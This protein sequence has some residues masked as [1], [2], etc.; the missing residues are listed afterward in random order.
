MR[1]G[2][3]AARWERFDAGS[4]LWFLRIYGV[5]LIVDVVTEMA[6]GVWDV[7][8]GRFYPWRH[9]G[10]VPLYPPAVLVVEWAVRIAGGLALVLGAKKAKTIALASRVLAIVLFVA[11]LQRYS[12]HGVLLL[13]VAFFLTLAPV[14]ASGF[15]VANVPHHA[16]GLLRAQLV[17]VY[18]FSALNKLTHGFTN[19]RSLANLL[20][21]TPTGTLGAGSASALSWL[22]V[23]GELA[24]PVLLVRSPRA[25]IAA[26][27]AMHGVFTALVPGVASFGLAMIAMAMLFSRVP[28]APSPSPSGRGDSGA[29]PQPPRT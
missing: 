7:H 5:A 28:G 13:L 23:A 1:P 3:V 12:N 10:I 20:H 18:V 15:D 25:G 6:S 16:L 26:A 29:L 21:A 2:D 27:I 4:V 14:D 11:I 9:L 17:I 19:G 8:A 22:V 24:I